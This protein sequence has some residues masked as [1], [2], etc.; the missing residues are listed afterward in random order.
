[1]S[2]ESPLDLDRVEEVRETEQVVDP[3]PNTPRRED[4]P[5][6]GRCE[7]GPAHGNAREVLAAQSEVQPVL[8]PQSL[9]IGPLELLPAARVEWVRDPDPLTRIR[10]D[11]CSPH[12]R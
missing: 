11:G 8:P 4:D 7:A 1:M 12:I 2:S 3:Q 9:V 6:I 10:R 5:W